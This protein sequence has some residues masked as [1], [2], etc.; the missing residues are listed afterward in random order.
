MENG[1]G[2]EGRG[3][4]GSR[5]SG[6]VIAARRLSL[7]VRSAF[8]VV[9]GSLRAVI[10]IVG[11]GYPGNLAG[12]QTSSSH[13]RIAGRFSLGERAA[14]QKFQV[15]R[16]R[17]AIVRHAQR[18]VRKGGVFA[19]VGDSSARRS[20]ASSAGR[21]VPFRGGHRRRRRGRF[22]LGQYGKALEHRGEVDAE[23]SSLDDLLLTSSSWWLRRRR[24]GAILLLFV[25][26]VL[27]IAVLQP[28]LLLSHEVLAKQSPGHVD[29]ALALFRES[30]LHVKCE[31]VRS[32]VHCRVLDFVRR[33][34]GEGDG[35]GG[36]LRR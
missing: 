6:I 14:L 23:F 24:R 9:D 5:Q 27:G 18:H 10:D 30:V 22:V 3:A 20:A 35:G 13:S 15:K 31:A 19:G 28:N 21:A 34:S 2:L 4:E 16:G 26:I 29:A 1:T 17:A 33:S 12:D 25:D 8:L 11:N 36:R 7:G 32:R